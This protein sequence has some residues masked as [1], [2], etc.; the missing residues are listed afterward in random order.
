MIC[1]MVNVSI[2]KYKLSVVFNR[3][4]KP[5]LLFRGIRSFYILFSKKKKTVKFARVCARILFLFKKRA[6]FQLENKNNK[7]F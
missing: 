7:P 3:I 5:T 6:K 1:G 4:I 2:A